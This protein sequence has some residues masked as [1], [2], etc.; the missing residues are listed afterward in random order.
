VEE[1]WEFA[2]VKIFLSWSG[3][4]SRDVAQLFATWIPCVLQQVD[5]FMS[6][7]AIEAG[8]RWNDVISAA[9]G[10]IDFGV[11]FITDENK[12]RP[13]LLFE[14]G[15]LAKD[16]HKSKVVPIL[17]DAKEI[18]LSKSPLFG[19]QYKDMTKEG[20]FGLMRS[21]YQSIKDPI[22]DRS[23]LS[24][25]LEKW[26]PELEGAYNKIEVPKPKKSKP[27][28]SDDER[29]NRI[30]SAISDVLGRISRSNNLSNHSSFFHVNED[31]GL[32]PLLQ[33]VL[34]NEGPSGVDRILKNFDPTD[35]DIVRTTLN[36]VIHHKN[37]KSRSFLAEKLRK[38]LLEIEL[39]F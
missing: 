31:V 2:A 32:L 24:K 28:L 14:A 1:A 10:E 13:W 21:I 8:D 27:K 9:L 19:F 15:A 18:D 16:I 33:D 30:E 38:K 17:I 35:E 25:C 20:V 23:T 7:N 26:W 3:D 37:V 22:I 39:P 4:Y 36:A 29:L 12:E 11:I 34:E 5:V 6:T